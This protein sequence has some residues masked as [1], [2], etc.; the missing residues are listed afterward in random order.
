MTPLVVSVVAARPNFV[1]MAPVIEALEE[2]DDLRQLIVHTGQHYD[3]EMSDDIRADLRFPS[4]DIDL[5][6]GSG[7]HGEQTGRTIMAFEQIL[8]DACPTMVIVAGDV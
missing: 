2:H 3:K 1:K 7:S 4:P 5:G 8:M 6:I